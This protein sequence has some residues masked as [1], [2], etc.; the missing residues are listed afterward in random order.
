M[1][2]LK[3]IFMTPEELQKLYKDLETEEKSLREQLDVIA[4]KNPRVEGDYEVKIPEYGEDEDEN[5][6]EATDLDR[7]MI[8]ENE[9]ETRLNE[10]IKTKK[11]IKQGIYGKK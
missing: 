2:W 10:V 5:A 8:L 6:H 7:N 11:E 3:L 9:L 4:Q 1:N